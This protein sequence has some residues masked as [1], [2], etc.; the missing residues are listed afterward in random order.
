[1]YS[2][3]NSEKKDSPADFTSLRASAFYEP[4]SEANEEDAT[5]QLR[6]H[7]P[8]AAIAMDRIPGLPSRVGGAYQQLFFG[9]D[10]QDSD[11]TIRLLRLYL[12]RKFPDTTLELAEGPVTSDL[13]LDEARYRC[14]SDLLICSYELP[15]VDE[16]AYGMGKLLASLLFGAG[17][18][19]RDIELVLGGD[20][21]R[22]GRCYV[23]DFN[24]CRQWLVPRYLEK[25][26]YDPKPTSDMYDANNMDTAAQRIAVMIASQ[27][28]YYPR[29]S[30]SLELFE[31]FESGFKDGVKGVLDRYTCCP[32]IREQ[33]SHAADAF[34]GEYKRQD[35]GK[36]P[37]R[38]RLTLEQLETMADSDS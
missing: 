31:Q 8:R 36:R 35:E 5:W 4:S 11:I 24:Q 10:I 2:V 12:G 38:P 21:R 32:E 28:F 19:C 22:S 9:P 23:L 27:E 6:A 30:V 15:D 37:R 13:P 29:P 1:M 33:V 18:D 17:I 26:K 20:G 16:V 25:N 3:L 7:F 34:L 14:L